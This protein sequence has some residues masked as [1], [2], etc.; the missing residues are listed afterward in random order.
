MPNAKESFKKD[1]HLGRGKRGM[2]P[3]WL[4]SI[5]KG[6]HRIPARCPL[7]CFSI[8]RGGEQPRLVMFYATTSFASSKK[9]S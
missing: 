5:L 7:T 6:M 9:V 3:P 8:V 1:V 2:N 4:T